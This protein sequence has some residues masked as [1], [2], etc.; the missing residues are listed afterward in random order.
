MKTRHTAEQIVVKLG[1]VEVMDGKPFPTFL[2]ATTPDHIGRCLGAAA[3]ALPD[4]PRT[5]SAVQATGT[6]ANMTVVPDEMTG[7]HGATD[8]GLHA[9]APSTRMKAISGTRLVR[10]RADALL[11]IRRRVC[12]VSECV[13]ESSTRP[14]VVVGARPSGESRF[15]ERPDK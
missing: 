8:G 13:M 14:T 7:G 2:S 12:G 3:V 4:H 6:G 15:T 11:L 10:R 9:S 1:E 5:H